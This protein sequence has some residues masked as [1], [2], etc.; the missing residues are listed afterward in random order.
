M[1][2][3]TID[4]LKQAMEEGYAVGAFNT[5]NLEI[6][7]G[8]VHAAH[9]LERPCI[10]QMTSNAMKYAGSN[11]LGDVVR[12]VI[13]NDSDSVPVGFHLDHGK[14]LDHVMD[15]IEA[16]VDSVMI[17]GSSLRFKENLEIT[18]R[19]V[20]YS[21]EREVT[22]QAEL[23][24]VPYLGRE[25][26][27]INW[28]EVMTNPE[29]A[30]KLVDETGIDALA[31][32]IGNAHGFFREREVPDWDRLEKIKA[33]IPQTPLIMHGA[34]DWTD[35]RVVQA[36]ER[37]IC[38]FNIDTDIRVA[39]ITKICNITNSKCDTTDPRKVLGAARKNVK[40]KVVEKIKMFANQTK[41]EKTSE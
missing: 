32:G 31:V 22:V 40:N 20:E 2:G 5:S 41:T 29:E 36:I 11:V 25:D 26:Q 23:G 15:A 19:I 38:C 1:R 35:D 34:S 6:T 9:K 37:G 27:E 30:K 18:K 21:H 14:S 28:D 24:R 3:K 12:S 39:F 17:D 33:L 10:V 16:G 13:E 7:Q 8:I 4:I